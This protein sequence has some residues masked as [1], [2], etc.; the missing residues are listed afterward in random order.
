MHKSSTRRSTRTSICGALASPDVKRAHAPSR[1]TSTSPVRHRRIRIRPLLAAAYIRLDQLQELATGT[2]RRLVL[3]PADDSLVVVRPAGALLL[4]A[5]PS[6]GS[7]LRTAA[8]ARRQELA[9][10]AVLVIERIPRGEAARLERLGC[11][12]VLLERTERTVL[13]PELRPALLQRAVPV[14]HPRV[15]R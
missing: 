8:H 3:G 11:L 7:R 15:R 2:T 12:Q 5:R 14:D 13:S 9:L 1:P 6:R 4:P 10:A